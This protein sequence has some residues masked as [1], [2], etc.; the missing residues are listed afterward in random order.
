MPGGGS[1]NP[2]THETIDQGLHFL[3]MEG[4]EV[5]KHAVRVMVEGLDAVM[6]KSGVTSDEVDLFIPHQANL[7]IIRAIADRLNFPEE[8]VLV[9]IHK[10][11][12]TS[13]ASIGIGLDEAVRSGRAKPGDVVMMS[14][15]GAGMTM[16]SAIVRL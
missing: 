11:G 5:F 10:Y 3:K 1:R 8:K 13:A 7:R 9:N 14:A 15:F 6:K 16:A 2:P 4:S 12:N